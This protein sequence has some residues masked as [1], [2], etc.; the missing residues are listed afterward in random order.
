MNG[1]EWQTEEEKTR[2]LEKMRRIRTRTEKERTQCRSGFRSED[3]ALGETSNTSWLVKINTITR[4]HHHE[5]LTAAVDV[6]RVISR[7]SEDARAGGTLGC[8][9][10]RVGLLSCV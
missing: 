6:L 2:D 1:W 5:D 9:V 3:Q 8:S 4:H 7:G 10:C